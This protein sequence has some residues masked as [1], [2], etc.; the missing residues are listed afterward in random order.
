MTPDR[1]TAAGTILTSNELANTPFES[2]RMLEQVSIEG[3]V[4]IESQHVTLGSRA[5]HEPS[6]LSINSRL[7]G[8]YPLSFDCD[9]PGGVQEVC[10]SIERPLSAAQNTITLPD[11]SGTVL[12]TGNLPNPLVTDVV[13]TVSTD[14]LVI[15]SAR[16]LSLGNHAESQGAHSGCFVFVDSL[17]LPHVLEPSSATACKQVAATERDNQFVA[18]VRGG[19]K[20]ETGKSGGGGKAL[21]CMLAAGASSWSSLSD[22]QVKTNVSR[23]DAPEVKQRLLELVPVR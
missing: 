13:Y 10:L 23:V 9:I 3:E 1:S 11:T 22:R 4:N 16:A 14:V 21:G 7:S 20:F 18:I 12:T 2:L 5:S 17:P 19:V 8:Q 15:T 6:Y